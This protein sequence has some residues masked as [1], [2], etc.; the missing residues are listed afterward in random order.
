MMELVIPLAGGLP[1]WPCV[2]MADAFPAG[3]LSEKVGGEL[4]VG[5]GAHGEQRSCRRALIRSWRV[6]DAARLAATMEK[7]PR[8]AAGQ[9]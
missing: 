3:A 1:V 8:R 4:M 6:R 9:A 7:G 2:W 5:S